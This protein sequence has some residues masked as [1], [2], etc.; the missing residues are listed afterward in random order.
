MFGEKS[1]GCDKDSA[2]KKYKGNYKLQEKQ[3][4]TRKSRSE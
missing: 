2:R 1:L 3:N 4:S